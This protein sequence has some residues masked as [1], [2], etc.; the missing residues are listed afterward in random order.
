MRTLEQILETPGLEQYISWSDDGTCVCIQNLT[1]FELY[2]LPKYFKHKNIRSFIRQLNMYGFKKYKP[3]AAPNRIKSECSKD[4][5]VYRNNLFDKHKPFLSSN[6]KRQQSR[7]VKQRSRSNSTAS[8]K[9]EPSDSNDQAM[10]IGGSLTDSDLSDSHCDH[11]MSATES[12]SSGSHSESYEPCYEPFR[13]EFFQQL[14]PEEEREVFAALMA[15]VP[16][17]DCLADYQ[18]WPT[19][20]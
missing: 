2:V 3:D 18:M 9:A 12:N 4:M 1:D 20:L 10:C 17:L 5:V 16:R 11:E 8:A 7:D 19:G 6:I 14:S 13:F 15:E